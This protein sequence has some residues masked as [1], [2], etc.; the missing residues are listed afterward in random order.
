MLGRSKKKKNR[1]KKPPKRKET[2]EIGRAPQSKDMVASF[3]EEKR[4]DEMMERPFG[5][6]VTGLISFHV[7]FSFLASLIPTPAF[8]FLYKH[9]SE[10]KL[11]F[12]VCE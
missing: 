10:E 3:Y 9:I 2:T 6:Y 12:I 1:R 4:A 5:H 8:S 11:C 7:P